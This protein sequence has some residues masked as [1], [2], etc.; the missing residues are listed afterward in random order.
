MG[1]SGSGKSTLLTFVGGLKITAHVQGVLLVDGKPCSRKWLQANIAFVEQHDNTLATSTVRETLTFAARLTMPPESTAEDVGARVDTVIAELELKHRADSYIGGNDVIRGLSGGERRR[2]S[3]GEQLVKDPQIILLD[4]PTS[5]LDATKALLLVQLLKKLASKNRTVLTVIHQPSSQA[6]AL[7]DKVCL[8]S[9]GRIMFNGTLKAADAFF[10]SHGLPCPPNYNPADHYLEV[11][12]D[13]T[14]LDIFAASYQQVAFQRSLDLKSKGKNKLKRAITMSSPSV[15]SPEASWSTQV[16][17]L[18][19]RKTHQWLRDPYMFISEAI[20]YWVAALLLG[21]IFFQVNDEV[22]GQQKRVTAIGLCLTILAWV[23]SFTVIMK[24]DEDRHMV[25]REEAANMYSFG[26]YYASM[27]IT[28][29]TVALILTLV[30][31]VLVY[32]LVGFRTDS[33]EYFFRFLAVVWTYVLTSETIGFCCAIVASNA[34]TGLLIHKPFGV[35]MFFLGGFFGAENEQSTAWTEHI[36]PLYYSAVAMARNE[37]VG[38]DDTFVSVSGAQVNGE[39]VIPVSLDNGLDY[40]KNVLALF[41]ILVG[42]R[43]LG[44]GLII[45]AYDDGADE[46]LSLMDEEKL[47]EDYVKRVNARLDF[48]MQLAKEIS[49]PAIAERKS[50]MEGG[51]SAEVTSIRNIVDKIRSTPRSSIMSM[52]TQALSRSHFHFKRDSLT[53]EGGAAGEK[54][55]KVIDID[56]KMNADQKGVELS[57]LA[58]A[59]KSSAGGKDGAKPLRLSESKRGSVNVPKRHSILAEK[60]MLGRLASLPQAKPDTGAR[61]GSIIGGQRAGARRGSVLMMKIKKLFGGM[62]R[63]SSSGNRRRRAVVEYLADGRL[64]L[65]GVDNLN[66]SPQDAKE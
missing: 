40:V 5:G 52:V 3:I 45:L 33:L 12:S 1:P 24:F 57:D 32:F 53:K 54:S 8:L 48:H 61:R 55:V 51:R 62:K 59:R 49:P 4:E 2:V 13:V 46:V 7:F 38:Q 60:K 64:R 58:D 43:I 9:S 27:T 26:A 17:H 11:I 35:I 20:Q 23:P 28:S 25:E 31:A 18:T 39:S 41:A 37:F 65:A 16:V 50:E 34:A 44:Y 10:S 36:N 15:S 6:F 22:I 30:Y 21:V 14:N 66:Q 42:T 63:P 47:N 29:W 19:I 56:V